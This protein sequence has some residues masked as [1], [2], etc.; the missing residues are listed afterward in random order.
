MNIKILFLIIMVCSFGLA[1]VSAQ[2]DSCVY[3][4]GKFSIGADVFLYADKVNVRQSDS[5][6][7]TIVC[8]L[9]IATPLKIILRSENTFELNGMS[10]CWYKVGF[11]NNGA[12]TTGYVW[13]NL[14]SF[15]TSKF[16]ENGITYYFV[17]AP[18][19][20]TADDGFKMTG[21]IVS[22]GKIISTV[23]FKPIYSEMSVSNSFGYGLSIRKI[24]PTGF[25]GVS[26]I[27]AVSFIYEACSFMNGD[28]LLFRSGNNLTEFARATKES[29][30]GIFNVSYTYVFPQDPGGKRNTLLLNVRTIQ[31]DTESEDERV[32]SDISYIHK[33]TWDG[34]KGIESEKVEKILNTKK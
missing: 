24:D 16:T 1:K 21:K 12:Y 20:K 29:E 11:T 4:H 18:S 14:I 23:V 30:A 15:A 28:V 5:P 6:T 27:F 32:T 3:L 33:I 31:Y 34:S 7:S 17:C 13:G 25:D 9:P 2:S 10:A 26:K 22:D 8:N 19:S